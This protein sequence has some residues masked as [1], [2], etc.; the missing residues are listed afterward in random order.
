MTSTKASMADHEPRRLADLVW[1]GDAYSRATNIEI[2]HRDPESVPEFK[3]TFKSLRLLEDVLDS[4]QGS[5]R[6]R[7]W[8]VVGPY[9]SGKSTFCLF[10]LQLL[11]GASSPWLERCLV[12]MRMANPAMEQRVRTHVIEAGIRYLPVIVQ[13]A[14]VPLDLALCRALHGSISE[15]SRDTSW[16]PESFRASLNITL[17]TLE[18]GVSDSNGVVELFTR[19]SKLAQEEGRYKGLL[20]VVDEFGKFLERAA[21]Q[22]DL[23]D[24][25]AAQYLAE[26]ASSRQEPELLFLVLLHQGFQ[27]YASSLSQR[28]WM[29]WAKIQGRFRQIDFNEEPDHLYDLVAASLKEVGQSQDFK[30][31]I[32]RW[33]RRTWRQV[34]SIQAFREH[35]EGFWPS[36]LPRVYPFHPIALYALPRLSARLGQNER[37]LFSFIASDDPLGLK[38]FLRSTPFSAGELTSLTLDYLFEYFLT[39]ARYSSLPPDVQR[40]VAEIDAALDRLGD[41]SHFEVRLLKV[42]AAISVLRAGPSLPA[43]E[44]VLAAAL[45][46]DTEAQL[47]ELRA[48]LAALVA[49]K[50]VVFRKFSNE[51]RI[52]QGSDFDFDAA[53]AKARED[54][55]A[56]LDL[57]SLLNQE[58][59][60]RPLLAH[61]HSFE[62]GTTRSFAMQYMSGEEAARTSSEALVQKLKTSHADGL[63]LQV[64]PSNRQELTAVEQWVK[65]LDD[66]QVIVVIPLEP[67]G[68]ANLVQDLAALRRIGDTWPELH[69]DPVATKELAARTESADELLREAIE[70]I[71]EPVSGGAAWFWRGKRQQVTDRRQMNRFLSIVCDHVY[72]SAPR[73]RNELINR[74]SLSSAIV[75]AV[76]KIVTGLVEGSGEPM[77]AFSGNGPE[78]SIFRTVFEAQDLYRRHEGGTH[79]LARPSE[80]TDSGVRVVWEEI[81]RFLQSTSNKGRPVTELYATLTAPPYGVREGLIPLL[82]WA[83]LLYHRQSACLYENGTYVRDWSAQGFD[84]FVK[85]PATFTTRWLVLAGPVGRLVRELNKTVPGS[86]DL[87]DLDGAVPL[88]GFLENL[89]RWYK[90]L[91]DYAKHTRDL[92]PAALELRKIITTAVDPIEMVIVKVPRA[93]GLQAISLEERLTRGRQKQYVDAFGAAVLELASAYSKLFNDLVEHL[94]T[95]FGTYILVADIRS[96]FQKLDSGVL[97]HVRDPM[98]KAFLVRARDQHLTEV[99]W[100]ESLAAALANQAPR[101]WMD[102]HYEEFLDKVSLVQLALTDARRRAYAR[103][104]P[105][106][107]GRIIL[108]QR[109]GLVVEVVVS[110]GD[111]NGQTA[112]AESVL[113]FLDGS[114]KMS[115]GQKQAILARALELSM[116]KSTNRSRE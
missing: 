3:F 99:Q 14:R 59:A 83:V 100:V 65:G 51:Y 71:T 6:D 93:L 84:R 47:D 45:D 116:T 94:S 52:W 30:G 34:Q 1:P 8:S 16:V 55:Q 80:L 40:R 32:D 10:L 90:S 82:T 22:G 74:K 97:E 21:W 42:L 102:H 19:A 64:L 25:M 69:D 41:R 17:Q 38:K 96:H 31:L 28:Q 78:V 58:L 43:S 44:E 110:E 18:A 4:C 91:P 7:A 103:G 92:D 63:V 101:F 33:T 37:T 48:A 108:E 73:I 29:E 89:Y 68:V 61:K 24:V 36:F 62:T 86:A 113:K 111:L 50:I 107:T 114:P 66:P 49:R 106:Q 77:L 115:R 46:L 12:R 95:T 56:G 35:Q 57:S 87:P 112:V 88:T 105:S 76:K 104:N 85:A 60:P 109:D 72:A 15:D 53:L 13:G 20:V 67:I 2:D 75:V 79:A 9:G 98:A 27:Q 81:E 11:E 70:A 5:R 23:P 54:V 26:S 39:G